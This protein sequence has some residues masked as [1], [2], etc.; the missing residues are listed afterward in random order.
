MV[1]QSLPVAP[2]LKTVH[3]IPESG[4]DWRAGQ[5][6]SDKVVF[7]RNAKHRHG[8]HDVYLPDQPPLCQKKKIVFDVA[9]T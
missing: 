1:N 2:F 9:R 3:N 4:L 5:P 8:L 7:F 6:N